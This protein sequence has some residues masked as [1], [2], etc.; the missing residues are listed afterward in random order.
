MDTN[1]V[2]KVIEFAR[3]WNN[4]DSKEAIAKFYNIKVSTVSNRVATL[5]KKG[6]KLHKRVSRTAFTKKE[7]DEINKAIASK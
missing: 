1:E 6:I 5:R 2:K 4:G 7:I 3:M